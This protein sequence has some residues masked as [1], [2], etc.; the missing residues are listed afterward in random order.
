MIYGSGSGSLLFYQ[1]L[2]ELEKRHGFINQR[3]TILKTKKVIVKVSNKTVCD[4]KKS[5]GAKRFV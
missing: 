1:R 5:K 3:K 2:E 4:N